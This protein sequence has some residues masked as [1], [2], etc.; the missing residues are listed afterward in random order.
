[1]EKGRQLKQNTGDGVQFKPVTLAKKKYS[2]QRA[3]SIFYQPCEFCILH[4]FPTDCPGLNDK[5]WFAAKSS[6]LNYLQLMELCR[7]KIQYYIFQSPLME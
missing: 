1:M 2:S 6:T 3:E 4:S 7:A 5:P